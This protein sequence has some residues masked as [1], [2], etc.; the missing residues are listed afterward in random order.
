MGIAPM[1]SAIGQ[2]NDHLS[3]D[4]VQLNEVRHHE[5]PYNYM[6]NSKPAQFLPESKM[7]NIIISQDTLKKF[8]QDEKSALIEIPISHLY[9]NTGY[10][11]KTGSQA[12]T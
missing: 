10:T 8:G 12:G 2:T 5:I 3:S 7:M 4:F 6:E 9:V 11:K 1:V